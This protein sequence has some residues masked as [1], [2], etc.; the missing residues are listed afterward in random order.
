MIALRRT[1]RERERERE[2]GGERKKERERER[3]REL[4]IE[5]VKCYH[6]RYRSA[7]VQI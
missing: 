6:C 3:G 5:I 4:M 7:E 1:K 2:R